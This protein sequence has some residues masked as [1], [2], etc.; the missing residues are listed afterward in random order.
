MA[1]VLYNNGSH[2]CVLF[3]DLVTGEAVQANQVMIL[4]QGHAAL[5]DPGGELTFG[6]L[7]AALGNFLDPGSLD[8]V[9]AS[10]Q[11]PDIV[12]SVDQWLAQTSCRIVIPAVWE[13]FIPHFTRPGRLTDRVISMP[14]EGLNL[15]LGGTHIQALP[16][17]FLHSEGNFS[18]YDPVSRILFSGDIGANFPGGGLQ[19]PVTR[20]AEVLPWMEPF[21]RR[22]MGSK[23]VCR[24][25]VEMVRELEV[26]KLVPQHGRVIAG[27]GA[28]GEFFDWLGTMEC[29]IDLVGQALYRPPRIEA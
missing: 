18:F 14:D 25:W 17:H 24:F 29:G 4:D 3:Q 12:S 8:Y 6:H 22:Y 20:L 16:A 26:D 11:D 10:H 13:R 2:V 23:K 27:P 5:L 21:H 28:V 19:E 1:L 15:P 9:L 7:Y